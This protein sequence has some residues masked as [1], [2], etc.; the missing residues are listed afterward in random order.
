MTNSEQNDLEKLLKDNLSGKTAGVP[1]F[2]WDRIEKEIYP[3]KKKRRFLWWFFMGG[4]LLL[5]GVFFLGQM[6]KSESRSGANNPKTLA[7]NSKAGQ[8]KTQYVKRSAKYEN[9]L[10]NPGKSNSVVQEAHHLERS[11]VSNGKATNIKNSGPVGKGSR[12]SGTKTSGAK[13]RGTKHPENQEK[14]VPAN[15]NNGSSANGPTP[16]KPEIADS[17]KN[18]AEN[19]IAEEKSKPADDSTVTENDLPVNSENPGAKQP[20]TTIKRFMI[21]L[22]SGTTMYDL[23]VFKDY[24]TSGQLSNRSFQSSGF[25]IGAGFSYK[26]TPKLGVYT[27][28][29]FN[30][31]NTSFN[32]NLAISEQQYFNQVLAGELLPI[33]SIIDNGVGNCFL[34][35]DV[36]ADYKIDSWLFSVG[37]TFEAFQ[38]KKLSVAADLRFSA[39]LNSALTIND[40]TVLQIQPYGKERFNYLKTGIGMNISYLLKERFSIG[41]A[42]MYHLQFNTDK[43]SFYKGSGKELVL[44]VRLGFCF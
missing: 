25:E 21:S 30:R 3:E 31:K 27:S 16:K 7:P 41:I 29:A 2:V 6:Q 38:W 24:F 13:S 11:L 32:Y 15:E 40:L 26:I 35:E 33:E 36:K 5:T 17:L 12:P 19:G 34:A 22:Y 42:P 20:R 18:Q 43:Q 28:A 10:L 37:T 1:D 14:L 4:I 39:N 9:K 8:L 44:P 23:A